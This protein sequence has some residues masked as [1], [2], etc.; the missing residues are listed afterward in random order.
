MFYGAGMGK[1]VNLA[2]FKKT[3]HYLKK[4]GPKEAC[5]AILERFGKSEYENYDYR[6][7]DVSELRRQYQKNGNNRYKFSIL[8][9]AYETKESH[10]TEMIE[11]VLA[12]TY[13]NFELI[14]ADASTSEQV[15]TVVK[16]YSDP[17]IVYQ[18]LHRNDGIAANSNA[19]LKFVTGDYIGLLDHDDLLTPD[20]LYEVE[21]AISQGKESG[22][23]Y[24][25]IYSNED[26]C[27][28]DA[29][30]FYEPNIKS[31]F[32]LDLILTNNYI[33]HFLVMEAPLMKGLKFRKEY[34][35]AQDYDILLRAI[36]NLIV[37]NECKEY[38]IP[39]AHIDKVLY[40]WRCHQASTAANPES[41]RYAYEAGKRAVED[42]LQRFNC[43]AEVL[44]TRHLGF[45]R[46]EYKES[47]FTQRIDIGVVGGKVTDSR[48]KITGGIYGE[49]GMPLY[50]G[51]SIHFSGYMNRAM[52][53]QSAY[54]IDVRHMI[55]RPELVQV[56]EE[57]LKK[58]FPTE[59]KETIYEK[60]ETLIS[61]L[62]E[63]EIMEL[64]VQ[65]CNRVRALGYRIMWDPMLP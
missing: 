53:Q 14:I 60:G 56:Y 51:L 2:N 9:P 12:Q 24:Q 23:R 26:K 17:R 21:K 47:I 44:H 58:K 40:H 4:N 22:M 34:D 37:E 13:T 50:K 5:F 52:L 6:N 42:I 15:A 36:G 62:S 19:A 28:E 43:K 35:G 46:V 8:V 54:A 39:I 49:Q 27:D 65:L 57:L 55:I 32:N 45:Y 29:K 30:Q 3:I 64:N 61:T 25:I 41:K 59:S 11:S 63:Q 18:K 10:L 31:K 1:R 48:N 38:S 7:P 20:A 16:K 33:C